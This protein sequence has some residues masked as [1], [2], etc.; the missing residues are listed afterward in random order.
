MGII[1]DTMLELGGKVTGVFAVLHVFTIGL[2]DAGIRAGLGEDFAEDGEIDTKGFAEREPFREAGGVDVH[3][4]V[5]E[6]F[7]VGGLAG[8]ADVA[9]GPAEFLEDGFRAVVGGFFATN[10]EVK[11]A[12]A[13]LG[14]AG[15][16]AGFE[17]FGTGG[18]GALFD[19]AM[20]VGGDGGAIDEDFTTGILEEARA[21]FGEDFVHG[22]VVGDDGDDHVRKFGDAREVFAGFSAE[23]RGEFLRDFTAGIVNRR[24]GVAAIFEAPSHVRAHATDSDKSDFFWHKVG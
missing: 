5:D 9:H 24:N 12:F 11:G 15:G 10:H 19:S 20:D 23:F 14:D 3:D 1:A 17:A 13:R 2:E 4:H 6:R 21:F 18:F 8:F 22:S 7:D 16:H